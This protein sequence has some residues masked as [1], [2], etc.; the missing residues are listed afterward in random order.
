ML[1]VNCYRISFIIVQISM[2]VHV[3]VYMSFYTYICDHAWE[4]TAKVIF[5]WFTIF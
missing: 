5:W 4:N 2:N 1:Y 3:H